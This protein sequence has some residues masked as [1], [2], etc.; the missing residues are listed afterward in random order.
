M[1]NPEMSQIRSPRRLKAYPVRRRRKTCR[2]CGETFHSC[3]IDA[4]TCSAQCRQDLHENGDLAY[5]TALPSA[6]QIAR[7]ALHQAED[8]E[9]AIERMLIDARRAGRKAAKVL[10]QRRALYLKSEPEPAPE[11]PPKHRGGNFLAV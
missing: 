7:R 5:I 11:E 2:A 1:S 10:K 6:Q 9:I 8:D 3:R 4:K